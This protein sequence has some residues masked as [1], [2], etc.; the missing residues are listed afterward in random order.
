[1]LNK[2]LYSPAGGGDGL[3][4]NEL[5]A[6]YSKWSCNVFVWAMFRFLNYEIYAIIYVVFIINANVC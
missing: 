6:D 5:S 1:M 4:V 2:M 3:F